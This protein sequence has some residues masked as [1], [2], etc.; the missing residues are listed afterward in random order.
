M[1]LVRQRLMMA[2]HA[3]DILRNEQLMMQQR[4]AALEMALLSVVDR[5]RGVPPPSAPAEPAAADGNQAAPPSGE[6]VETSAGGGSSSTSSTG[7]S[8][9]QVD[10][11]PA[12]MHAI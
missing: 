10:N 7:S 9:E 3:V 6:P 1:P 5:M 12:V 4:L 11:A 2:E 8:F